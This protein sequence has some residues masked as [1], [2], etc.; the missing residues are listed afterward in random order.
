VT[1]LLRMALQMVD[2]VRSS[3]HEG[4]RH[5]AWGFRTLVLKG[6]SEH[7][8]KGF[9][10]VLTEVFSWRLPWRAS[11]LRLTAYVA[12]ET[13]GIR[14]RYLHAGHDGKKQQKCEN[15]PTEG[16]LWLPVENGELN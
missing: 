10:S 7:A 9:A 1:L 13:H 11:L 14:R 8:K 2:S 16:H 12:A 4:E 6:F 5:H 15:K 3:G